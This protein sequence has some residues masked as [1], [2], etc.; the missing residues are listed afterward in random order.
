MGQIWIHFLVVF[1]LLLDFLA[2]LFLPDELDVPLEVDCPDAVFFFL[3]DDGL[4]GHSVHD[5]N[6]N[7]L[8]KE[9][10]I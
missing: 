8:E 3:L 5:S 10:E 4:R 6:I 9:V 1:F 7:D 2:A